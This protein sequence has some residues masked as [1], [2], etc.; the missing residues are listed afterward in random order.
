MG[1]YPVVGVRGPVLRSD[2]HNL[3]N[4]VLAPGNLSGKTPSRI[5]S[6]KIETLSLLPTEA[7]DL[8]ARADPVP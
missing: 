4:L 8:T 2:D 3:F 5:H 1:V 6:P 7:R